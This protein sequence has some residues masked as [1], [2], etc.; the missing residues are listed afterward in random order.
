MASNTSYLGVYTVA[1]ALS[2]VN[3]ASLV[4][5]KC[6]AVRV[7]DLRYK[8]SVLLSTYL[9]DLICYG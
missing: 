7:F 9:V 6:L 1:S 2:C 3:Y 8:G 5:Y 4:S